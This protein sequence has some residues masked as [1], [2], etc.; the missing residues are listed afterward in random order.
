MMTLTDF[1]S[2]MEVPELSLVP[3]AVTVI[4]NSPSR[5]TLPENVQVSSVTG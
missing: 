2:V 1:E 3:F 5:S 4:I